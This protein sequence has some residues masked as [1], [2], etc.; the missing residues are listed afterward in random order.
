MHVRPALIFIND[1]I[2][3]FDYSPKNIII[4]EITN[5]N[6]ANKKWEKIISNLENETITFTNCGFAT[7][8]Y[9]RRKI[10]F[11]G[12]DAININTYL[13]DIDKYL[14]DINDKNDD[15]LFSF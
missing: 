4:F 13:Y 5:I 1:Y 7:S 9:G 11:C 6:N 10:L 14:I 3:C 12:G 15:I 2:Y 8:L